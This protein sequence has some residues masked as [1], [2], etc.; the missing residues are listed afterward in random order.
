M[1]LINA[2][3]ARAS[4][5]HAIERGVGTLLSAGADVPLADPGAG[6]LFQRQA[7]NS[8]RNPRPEG[9]PPS[10]WSVS[11]AAGYSLTHIGN[12]DENGLPFAVYEVGGTVS[13]TVGAYINLP[14]PAALFFADGD[15]IGLEAY[16]A[17]DPTFANNLDSTV[18]QFRVHF[19]PAAEVAGQVFVPTT[20]PLYTQPLARQRVAP[21]GTTNVQPRIR[22]GGTPGATPLFRIRV[23]MAFG[24]IVGGGSAP[25]LPAPGDLT[26]STRLTDAASEL[27]SRFGVGGGG[28][29]TILARVMLLAAAPASAAQNL[30]QVDDGTDNNRLMVRNLAGGS[31]IAPTRVLA[32]ASADGAAAAFTPGEYLTYAA[33]ISAGRIAVSLNQGAVQ[34]VTGGPTSGLTHLRFGPN[35]AGMGAP[36]AYLKAHR[37]IPY[38]LSDAELPG[39]LF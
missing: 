12:G 36:E 21:V 9:A 37:I 32:G 8:L 24:A 31:T 29:C 30:I 26:A 14:T 23:G 38:A 39:L 5:A 6:Y 13:S 10:N 17:L 19:P 25:V 33:T 18:F 34:A 2:T 28:S 35:L 3:F 20:A 22:I 1:A 11:P 4:A 16:A 7:T 15:N 27:L